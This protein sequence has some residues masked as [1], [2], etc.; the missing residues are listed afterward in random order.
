MTK[1]TVNDAVSICDEN[2]ANI[3]ASNMP[4]PPGT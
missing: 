1:A 4:T 3:I 2:A